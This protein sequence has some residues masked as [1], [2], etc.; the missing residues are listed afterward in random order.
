MLPLAALCA[1]QIAG[2]QSAE[3][4]AAL[5]SWLL[6]EVRDLRVELAEARLDRQAERIRLL[7]REIDAAR[8]IRAKLD[9][10]ERSQQ[11]EL[12]RFRNQ[13]QTAE[14]NSAERALV[15]TSNFQVA[16]ETAERIRRE[17]LAAEQSEAAA[18]QDLAREKEEQRKLNESLALLRRTR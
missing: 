16:A 10:E 9:V 13:L 7:Q 1:I 17:R 18:N 11:E 14:F 3:P 4:T 5:F 8:T 2:A 6:N 15:E 12:M